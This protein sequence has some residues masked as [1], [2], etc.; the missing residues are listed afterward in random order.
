[1]FTTPNVCTDSHD[2]SVI[3]RFN[4]I[5]RLLKSHYWTAAL[6][7]VIKKQEMLEQNRWGGN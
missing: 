5:A 3:V 2:M 6:M 4:S 1:M 7:H